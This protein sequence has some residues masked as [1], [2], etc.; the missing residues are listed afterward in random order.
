MIPSLFLE[1]LDH[2]FLLPIDEPLHLP[3]QTP[4]L[5]LATDVVESLLRQSYILT[6]TDTDTVGSIHRCRLLLY[7]HIHFKFV[8]LYR[9]STIRLL[10]Y[11]SSYLLLLLAHTYHTA[12]P[13]PEPEPE[14]TNCLTHLAVPSSFQSP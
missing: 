13:E 14:P 4:D 7:S 5:C 8:L 12:V 1:R 11:F 2:L 10:R 6:T 9:I 3:H